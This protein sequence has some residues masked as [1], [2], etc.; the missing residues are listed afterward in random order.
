MELC[1]LTSRDLTRHKTFS[2]SSLLP[3]SARERNYL[4]S[5]LARL[6]A[7]RGIHYNAKIGS[8]R[9]HAP[10]TSTSRE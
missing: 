9:F 4:C 7:T 6:T 3:Q 8:Y 10:V 5:T 1:R 2:K